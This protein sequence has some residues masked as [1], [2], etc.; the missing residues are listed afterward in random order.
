M[1]SDLGFVQTQTHIA[2]NYGLHEKGKSDLCLGSL[3]LKKYEI[4][5]LHHRRPGTRKGNLRGLKILNLPI[6]RLDGAKFNF[7]Q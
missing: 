4:I 6:R 7:E 3:Y 1:N 2:E 5:H